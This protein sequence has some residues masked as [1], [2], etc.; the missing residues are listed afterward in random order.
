MG[1]SGIDTS[2]MTVEAYFAFTDVSPDDGKWELID[3]Q[4]I[5]NASPSV[6]HQCIVANLVCSLALLEREEQSSWMVLPG[7]GLRVSN[8]SL[9]QPDALILPRGGDPTT[10]ECRD[11]IVPFEIMSPCTRDRDLNWKRVAYAGMRSVTHYIVIEQDAVDVVVFAR[12][13]SFAERR[14]MSIHDVIEFRALG[15]S[16][17]LSE[18]YWD[19]GLR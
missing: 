16:L 17:P 11:P 9:P 5:L 7:L 8:I 12:E 6:R 2:P 1:A 15:V 3:G 18:V 19:T 4:P 10:R 14:L 13:N